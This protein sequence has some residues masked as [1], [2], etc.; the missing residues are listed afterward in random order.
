MNYI[1]LFISGAIVGSF[2]NVVGLRWNSGVGVGGR[3]FCP[4]CFKK[5]HWYELVPIVS[6]VAQRARCRGCSSKVSWQYPW[7]EFLTGAMFATL[8]YTLGFSSYYLL[9]TAVFCIYIVI[10]IYDIRHKIIPDELV[11]SAI[12][13][14]FVSLLLNLSTFELIDLL[15]GPIIFALFA[16]IWLLSKGR[17]LGFGDAKLGLSI[18]LLLG[19][20]AGFSAV[21]LAFWIGAV[22]TLTYMAISALLRRD[23]K[24]TMKSEVP[25]APFLVLGAWL[26]LIF[27]LDL[28]HVALF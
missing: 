13:L 26:G 3:S 25:F 23:K 11:Y 1:I 19:A 20:S 5:L 22:V 28:L 17:A 12:G 10:T 15:A 14:S 2:L 7:V 9:S 8:F 24:L 16:L 21:V 6:F 27:K 4:H 18:G